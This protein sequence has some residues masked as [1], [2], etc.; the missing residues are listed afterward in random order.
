[1]NLGVLASTAQAMKREHFANHERLRA[2]REF[3]LVAYVTRS[4]SFHIAAAFNACGFSAN[5]VTVVSTVLGITGIV[6][7]GFAPNFF[8][9]ATGTFLV[10]LWVVCD[11][12]D[13]NLARYQ[14]AA[15]EFGW[16]I[17]FVSGAFMATAV[18]SIATVSATG[19]MAGI[20]DASRR[21]LLWRGL[22]ASAAYQLVLI[23]SLARKVGGGNAC[24]GTTVEGGS[25]FKMWAK[26]GIALINIL[27]I[28][29]ICRLFSFTGG[30]ITF[31]CFFNTVALIYV[32]L[33]YGHE[34]ASMRAKHV[35]QVN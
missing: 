11:S 27:P 30:F 10:L 19:C 24:R 34:L 7:L 26:N 12:V 6:L 33:V 22:V 23:V 14:R 35:G 18:F 21:G 17:D 9:L 20:W 13:G 3:P 16:F 1:M 8:S 31:Y 2:D 25:C 28:F 4:L 15:S 32:M 5:Q 29:I